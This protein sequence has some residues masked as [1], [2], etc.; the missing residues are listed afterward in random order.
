[1]LVTACNASKK[2]TSTNVVT[3]DSVATSKIVERQAEQVT[4]LEET[5]EKESVLKDT[6]IEHKERKAELTLEPEEQEVPRTKSGRAVPVYRQKKQDGLTIW[7]RI[8]TNGKLTIGAELDKDYTIVRN[9]ES[10]K[11]TITRNRDNA[12]KQSDKQHSSE[13]TSSRSVSNT[14]TTITKSKTLWGK[15][16]WLIIAAIIVVAYLIIK[17]IIKI[18]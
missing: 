4:T 6:V 12:V 15:Y 17:R 2:T 11:E 10:E 14:Q 7:A 16:W 18:L 9:L 5:R 3:S 13:N 8:D 1:M